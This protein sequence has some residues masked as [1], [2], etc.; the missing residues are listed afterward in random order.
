MK[1]H[2]PHL[3]DKI[4]RAPQTSGAGPRPLS[5]PGIRPLALEQRLMFDGAAA[6]DVAHAVVEAPLPAADALPLPDAPAAV[7]IRTAEVSQNQGRKEAVF[8]DTTLSDWQTL[9]AGVR[10]GV[11]IVTF[12]GTRDGLAQIAAWAAGQQG[13]DAFHILSHGSEG[14]VNLGTTHLTLNTLGDANVQARLAT[15]GQALTHDGDLLLYGCDIAAGTAGESLITALAAA[16]GADVA[17]STDATGAAVLGGNWTLEQASGSIESGLALTKAGAAGYGAL[18]ETVT[19]AAGSAEDLDFGESSFTRTVD[20]ATF[21]FSAGG[22][23]GYTGSGVDIQFDPLIEPPTGFTGLSGLSYDTATGSIYR[24]D[25]TV[26][27]AA[28]Y[29]FDLTGFKATNPDGSI[30]VFY[31]GDSS[32]SQTFN[33][34]PYNIGNW[35]GLTAFN[36]I[37]SITFSSDST[38]TFIQDL[39]ITDV[40]PLA[41]AITNAIYDAQTNVL[42][43]TGSGMTAG[44]TIDV[45][46]LTLTGQGGA[47]YTLT[48][49]NVTATSPTNFSVTL[50]TI[51]Q[52]H[53]EGLLNNN[54]TTAVSGTTFNLAG[55]EGWNATWVSTTPPGNPTP[56][57]LTGNAVTVNNVQTPTITSASYDASTGLL[58]VTGSNLVKQAGANNDIDLSKL[59]FT[60]EG[61]ATYTLTSSAIET[62]S[63]TGFSIALNSTDRAALNLMLN[64][65]GSASSGGTT[66]NLAAADDWNG[67]ITGG[68]IADASNAVTVSNVS[69]PTITSA[70][71]DASSGVLTVTGTGFVQKSGGANDIDASLLSLTGAGGS[72][73][74]TDTADVEVASPTNFTLTLSTADRLAVNGLLNRNGSSASDSTPYNLAAALG[75]ATGAGAGTADLTG[76]SIA[77]SNVQTPSITS[78]IYD[79]ETG[80]LT[81]TGTNLFRQLGPANDIDVTRLTLTGEGGATYTLTGNTNNVEILSSTSFVLT[82]GSSDRA[83][84]ETL[85]NQF[86]T[87]SSGGTLYNLAAADDWLTAADPAV[88]IADTS[89]GVT[90]AINPKITSATYDPVNGTLVVTG[91]NFQPNGSGMD[92]DASRFTLTGEGGATWT[93]TDTADVETASPTAFTLTLS[94]TDKAA[95]NLILNRAG[96]LS[97]GG[98]TYNLAAADGWNTAVTGAADAFDNGITVG[99]VA[100]P[101]I[102]SATYNAATGVLTVSGTGFLRLGSGSDNNDIDVTKLSLVGED[103]QSITLSGSVD[104]SNGTS[105]S[106]TLTPAEQAAVNQIFNKNGSQSTGGTTYNLA[107]AEDWAAG[108]EASLV[109]ADLAGNGITV[110]N[111]AIPTITSATYDAAS[112]TLNVTGTGFL[113]LAGAGNDIDVSK[114]SLV[115]EGG[116]SYTLTSASVDIASGTSFS[117]TLSATDRAAVNQ[118]LNKNGTQSSG[119]TAYNLAAAEDWAAGADVAVTV[120]DL[121]GNGITVSN[122]AVP[123]ITGATYDYASHTLTVT[124]TGFLKLAGANNDIDVSRLRIEGAGGASYTLNVSGDV[125]ISSDTSFTV[126]LSGADIYNV[127]ALLNQNGGSASDGAS[128]NLAALEDWAAGAD[129]A[130]TVAD[131]SGNGISVSNYTPPSITSATYNALTGRL[132]VTGSHFVP[133]SGAAND[134]L[135]AGLTFTGEDGTTYTLT[136]SSNVE[137]VSSTEF[138]VML[139]LTDRLNVNGLLNKNGTNA[140]DNT[141]YNLAAAD[142]WMAGSPATLNIADLTGN[143][144]TV[145]NVQTPSL[146]YSYYDANT[147]IL[148]VGGSNLFGKPG[149]NNDIDPS[150]FTFTGLGGAG[151]AYTL[152]DTNGTEV[153]FDGSE[154]SFS[155]TLSN[156]DRTAVNA[157]LDQS[158]STQASDSTIYNLAAA[159]GWLTGAGSA[160][161]A[162]ATTSISTITNPSITSAVYDAAA[163]TLTVTGENFAPDTGDDIHASKFTL[164]GEGGTTWTLTDTIGV[165]IDS[166]TQFTL[167]LSAADKAALNL[168]LNKNGSTST[169]GTTFHLAAADDWGKNTGDVSFSGKSVNVTNVAV[170]AITNATY[171]AVSGVLTITGTGFLKLGG[172][173][174]DIDITKLAII[175]EGGA[176]HTLTSNNVEITSG[177]SFSVT[178]NSG[179]QTALAAIFS[180]NGSN[181]LDGTPY[182]LAAA[183]DWASGADAA[184]T[185]ADLTGNGITVSNLNNLPELG[186]TFTTAGTLDDNAS[187]TPFSGVTFSEADGDPVSLSI[188][189]TAANGTLSG[190]GLT[191]TAGSYTLSATDAAT[192]QNRLQ[193]VVFTPSANQAAPG[194]TV[195]TTFTLTPSDSRGTGLTNSATQVTTTSINDIPV[196]TNLNGDTVSYGIGGGDVTLDADGNASVT[197]PDLT[198]L[199][200]GS[201]TVSITANGQATD[202]VLSIAHQGSGAGQIGIS[203]S[204]VSYGGTL[205]GSFT[206]GSNGT[207]LVISLNGAATP[208]AAQALLGALTYTN[209][210]AET[211]HTDPRTVQ[212]TV[213]DGDGGTSAAQSI[214]ITLVR[215]PLIDLDGDDASGATNSGYAGTFTEN[216]G[217]VAIA[218]GDAT[219]TDDGTHLNQLLITLTNAQADDVL[220]LAG[221]ADGSTFNGISIT[222]T[223]SS[224]ITLSGT[225]SKADYLTLLKAARFDNSSEAPDSTPRSITFAARDTDGN[226]GPTATATITVTAV[227][228]APNLSGNLTLPAINEDT[229]SPTGA[230]IASL[231]SGLYSDPDNVAETLNG[232]AIIGNTANATS[233]GAWQYSTDAGSTWH[234]VGT[235]ADGATALALSSSTRLRFLPA[236]D[237]HGTPP[238]LSVR[239]LDASY[240]AGWSSGSTRV[241]VDTSSNGGTTAISATTRSITTSITS[242]ND[243]P[244]VTVSGGFTPYTAG[245]VVDAALTLADADDTNLTRAVITITNLTDGASESLA[246]TSAAQT[247]AATYGLTVDTYN[248][249]TG[250]LTITGTATTAQ[251]QEV[252]RGITYTN[253]APSPSGT[254]RTISFVVR[255]ASG[256]VA[257]QDSSTT[258]QLVKYNTP[259]VATGG[260][261][262]STGMEGNALSY[263]LPAGTF[264]DADGD[265]LT[266]SSTDKPV[267]LNIDAT[268]GTLSGTPPATGSYTLTITATDTAGA[269]ATKSIVITVTSAPSSDQHIPLPPAPLAPTAPEPTSPA[270]GETTPP[271][272]TTAPP[273]TFISPQT[274]GILVSTATSIQDTIFQSP[275]S[276]PGLQ[277]AGQSSSLELTRPGSAGS[278]QIMVVPYQPGTPESLVV[279]RGMLDTAVPAATAEMTEIIVPFDAFAHT[280]PEATVTLF[281]AQA[282]GRPLPPWMRFD[283]A[284]GKLIFKAPPGFQGELALRLVARDHQGREAVLTFRIV[285]GNESLQERTAPQGRAG[286]AEQLR[287]ASQAPGLAARLMT[288]PPGVP[289]IE[290]P[291]SLGA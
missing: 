271:P 223:S 250:T 58:T 83:A 183:E 209:T 52:L 32:N 205:I 142:D 62:S 11:A 59:T 96:G 116:Q 241:T 164:T 86:G 291:R 128:Y 234:N 77:V 129:S 229:T 109:V 117:L 14:M 55:A 26:S 2:L 171:D 87:S 71:Y 212:V 79:S 266:Y 151:A 13:Y 184:V 203:G 146:D 254:G 232:L 176:S 7:E 19:F 130:V 18:L 53:V 252:L 60:G 275:L 168:I 277:E 131:M 206:G 248:I 282:D 124:G 178:L 39:I 63:A 127:A 233:E 204:N 170:P 194:A 20:S 257:T 264:T 279:H 235:V 106:V 167:I 89:S 289:G 120:A 149:A 217:A 69:P 173:N 228:D 65:N 157:L 180:K 211:T 263:A 37:S 247:A 210:D 195:L 33:F 48:S 243:A 213:S 110:S 38:A 231:A 141:V 188:T 5:F 148:T 40:K 258:T 27:V 143:P 174:N 270:A 61:G 24:F 284:S 81:V 192:L 45:S 123:T 179:D 286:L 10:E 145:S 114:L 165:E 135:A 67:P 182:N 214:T 111:V 94:A 267:W 220:S 259:P 187:T 70:S 208:A 225:G 163:G 46:K 82:L 50:N 221:H 249:G 251:Y 238:E 3:L 181:A 43:V 262:T 287:L 23:A 246:L 21:T 290:A 162:D 227:N 242:E 155:L 47:S 88:N 139:S 240:S 73:T 273:L 105:F 1:A 9:A 161:I 230:T 35:S 49:A 169:G 166:S 107:A 97:T 44:D 122:V 126:V 102:T 133:T 196:I 22:T 283:P 118:F 42:T 175:G 150:K 91:T 56:A 274:D 140:T 93:L 121:T 95:I 4:G 72:Y 138:T 189:Y 156:T 100:A 125:E 269:T 276:Q 99:T 200:N 255:D 239:A 191:G 16:T 218:D 17:A 281:M 285:I 31:N 177:T 36:D 272:P 12:D 190:T 57:D 280:N 159:D 201:V 236:A 226:T 215:A 237:Y 30:T 76:N 153:Q 185:V 245:V 207:N 104:V 288:P 202:D 278:F 54:G 15:L 253:N 256:E 244:V 136:D 90:V 158:W 186:G 64:K 154:Y 8:I 137:I 222:Y 113:Q 66:Y 216:G 41:P 6:V 92:I 78:A 193:A 108:A 197:D 119:S 115:G 261:L 152:T 80:T 265:T 144:I 74:L 219:L 51:D 199:A 34:T 147:G 198:G 260:D 98:A 224:L 75:W 68:N 28:G 112:G 101:A 132:D 172:A 160:L 85:L 84:V 25:I 134:V 103:G 268:T 29:T